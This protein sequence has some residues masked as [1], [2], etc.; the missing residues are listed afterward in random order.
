MKQIHG[1]KA[2]FN[3][4]APLSYSGLAAALL[5]D[6]QDCRLFIYGDTG[7]AASVQLAELQLVPQSLSYDSFDQRIDFTLQGN[8]QRNDCVPLTY[9]LQGQQFRMTGRCSMIGRVCGVDLYLSKTYSGLV[10]AAVQ[11]RISLPLKP[12]LEQLK[13][14]SNA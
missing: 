4:Q 6:L 10:G 14:L 5:F 12:L 9:R 13:A 3:Q 7:G 1:V 2:L 8:I 11:Q